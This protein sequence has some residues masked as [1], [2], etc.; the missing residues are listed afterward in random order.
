MTVYRYDRFR[1]NRAV[2]SA[3][4]VRAQGCGESLTHSLAITRP[5]KAGHG[6]TGLAEYSRALREGLKNHMGQRVA[7]FKL[8]MNFC[9]HI[10]A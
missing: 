6:S 9:M 7:A 10:Y 1:D 5:R 3:K 4:R 8:A 2:A